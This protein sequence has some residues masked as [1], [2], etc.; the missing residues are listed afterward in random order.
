MEQTIINFEDPTPQ[1]VLYNIKDRQ[2]NS[3]IFAL[4]EA[5]GGVATK[6]QARLFG[7]AK[8]GLDGRP[9]VLTSDVANTEP[10]LVGLCLYYAVKTTDGWTVPL[11]QSGEDMIPDPTKLVPLSVIQSWKAD[12]QK[13]LFEKI[14]EMCPNLIPRGTNHL[15]NAL[16]VPGSPITPEELATWAREQLDETEHKD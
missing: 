4:L 3:R 16:S 6:Y 9:T 10:F 2:G 7:A 8:P 5:T 13:M 12:I 14:H 11:I 1:F 15:V